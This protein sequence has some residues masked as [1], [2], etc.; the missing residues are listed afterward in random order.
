LTRLIDLGNADLLGRCQ[1]RAPVHGWVSITRTATRLRLR[2][3]EDP[4]EGRMRS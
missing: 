2:D 4:S 3:A 1:G